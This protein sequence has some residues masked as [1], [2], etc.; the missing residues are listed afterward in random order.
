MCRKLFLPLV[1]LPACAS[2]RQVSTLS[3]LEPQEKVLIGEVD[4]ANGDLADWV[5]GALTG[6]SVVF[7]YK[8]PVKPN[9]RMVLTAADGKDVLGSTLGSAG[10]AFMVRVKNQMAYLLS[11]RARSTI[12]LVDYQKII[13]LLVK[14]EPS[15]HRCEYIGSFVVDLAEAGTGV[16]IEDRF[17]REARRYGSLVE[18]CVLEK[19]IA[20]PITPTD[21]DLAEQ[22]AWGRYRKP[23]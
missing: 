18:G 16:T 23:R 19:A 17:D 12:L 1:L 13:P 8:L 15:A 2:F 5:S 9:G 7:D 14:V 22:R 21:I 6:A 3:D 4:V 20:K 11:I 10:G